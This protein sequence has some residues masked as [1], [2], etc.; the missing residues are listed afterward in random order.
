[1]FWLGGPPAPPGTASTKLLGWSA[2]VSN[3][4]QING[5]RKESPFAFE[6]ARL[7]DVDGDG[8]PEYQPA[9]AS[10]TGA[11]PPYVYFDADS[12][13]NFANSELVNLYPCVQQT[14]PYTPAHK[15]LLAQ[16]GAVVPYAANVSGNTIAMVNPKKFQI[17][18]AG[19]DSIYTQ[20]N[21]P[22][23]NLPEYP[24]GKNYL[25]GDEDNLTNFSEGTLKDAIK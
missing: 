16:W 13:D 1:M 15:S 10:S 22:P 5:S 4:F 23:S 8:W 21:T 3:P 7:V 25:P 9:V 24:S 19:L 11:T 12:Y 6:E 18:S 2:N 20:E 14:R 17:I